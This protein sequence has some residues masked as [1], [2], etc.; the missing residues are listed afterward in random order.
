MDRKKQLEELIAFNEQSRKRAEKLMKRFSE[1]L[2]Y[3]KEK[4]AKSPD[5]QILSLQRALK[6]N[7]DYSLRQELTAKSIVAEQGNFIAWRGGQ[8]APPQAE[9]LEVEQPIFNSENALFEAPIVKQHFQVLAILN[10]ID[11]L[12]EMLDLQP[13]ALITLPQGKLTYFDEFM[14]RHETRSVDKSSFYVKVYQP[15]YDTNTV[16]TSGSAQLNYFQVPLGGTPAGSA[17]PKTQVD[18]NMDQGG[19]LP[20]PKC[21]SITGISIVPEAESNYSDVVKGLDKSWFRL[22][23]GIKDYFVSP[24]LAIGFANGKKSPGFS[25]RLHNPMRP[26]LV[27]PEPIDLI[28]Q[29]NFR[30][31]INFPQPQ[32]L[33]SPVRIKVILHGYFTREVKRKDEQHG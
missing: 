22:F 10:D 6:E 12:Q 33:S 19:S 14:P 16:A 17:R 11:D 7:P 31:E 28:P 15:L 25:F 3:I 32:K 26:A 9:Y 24:T 5:P 27:F 1:E 2:N 21:F 23:V 4:E 18:T 30:C 29:Q 13:D 20:Y 8:G